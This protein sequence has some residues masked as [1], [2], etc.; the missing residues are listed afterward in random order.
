[1]ANDITTDIRAL[2]KDKLGE[3][4]FLPPAFG[5][6]SENPESQFTVEYLVN[7]SSGGEYTVTRRGGACPETGSTFVYGLEGY[8]HMKPRDFNSLAE[9]RRSGNWTSWYHG[10]QVDIFYRLGKQCGTGVKPD[11]PDQ[12][13]PNEGMVAKIVL[14]GEELG[15]F[16]NKYFPHM[17]M[18]GQVQIATV[19]QLP[20]DTSK[21]A[22]AKLFLDAVENN[23]VLMNY[24]KAHLAVMAAMMPGNKPDEFKV[25]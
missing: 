24:S 4:R 2:G 6:S 14:G 17:D 19:E 16:C 7:I 22:F 15:A 13:L 12:D 5:Y 3:R 21:E 25:G 23:G 11:K 18:F 9:N 20:G 10:S 8:V 1:M